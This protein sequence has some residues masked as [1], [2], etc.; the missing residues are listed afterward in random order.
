M[1][2]SFAVISLFVLLAITS[3]T[4]ANQVDP[5]Y[6]PN[7]TIVPTSSSQQ[8]TVFAAASLTGAFQEIGQSFEVEQPGVRVR[9]NFAGSQILR[10]QLEQGASADVFASADH[11]NVDLLVTEKLI[12]ANTAQ[13]FA[14][15]SLVVILPSSNPGKV[16]T[17]ADLGRPGIKLV[18]ADAS[19]PAGNY[20]RQ[21][22]DKISQDQAYGADF[23][24]KVLGNVVSNETDVK[25]VVTKVELGEADAGIV[26][27]SDAKAAPGLSTLAIPTIFN[28][29]ASYPIA[30]LINA[31]NK[32]LATEFV[33]YVL[34]PA[35]QVI[36]SRWGFNPPVP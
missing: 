4:T 36:L 6:M 16:M 19:V 28:V 18:L 10:T 1:H 8:L 25:Q 29:R 17:L 31:P 20:A 11:Q 27:T 24:T 9:F 13:D 14:S 15:N 21:V 12:S 23:V 35:G 7:S 34:S 5:S 26:Y 30:D 2:K 3:C 32:K 33:A 22:L